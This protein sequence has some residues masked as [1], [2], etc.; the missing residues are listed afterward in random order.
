MRVPSSSGVQG[1]DHR[2]RVRAHTPAVPRVVGRA[3]GGVDDEREPREIRSAAFD[4]R[5]RHSGAASSGC[6]AHDA[7]ARGRVGRGSASVVAHR[8]LRS[9]PLAS[10]LSLKPSGPKNLMPLSSIGLCDALIMTP[11]AASA[12]RT[13]TAGHRPA[14][15]RRRAIDR[16]ASGRRDPR[17]DGPPRASFPKDAYR[18][19]SRSAGP[20]ARRAGREHGRSGAADAK[21]EFRSEILGSRRRARRRCRRGAFAHRFAANEFGANAQEIRNG[22]RPPGISERRVRRSA[23]GPKHRVERGRCVRKRHVDLDVR[24]RSRGRS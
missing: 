18:A 7:D 13:V 5:R 22:R 6:A 12:E 1:V 2:R 15:A 9:H 14:S 19:R 21:G 8:A 10:S 17:G 4:E 20:L 16:V 24:H 23:V 3:V 11:A